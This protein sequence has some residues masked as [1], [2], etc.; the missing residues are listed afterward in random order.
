[1]NRGTSSRSAAGVNRETGGTG[2]NQG[3]IGR[4]AV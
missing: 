4:P 3:S 1:V 2:T